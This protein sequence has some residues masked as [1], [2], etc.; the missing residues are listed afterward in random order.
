MIQITIVG[1]GAYGSKIS[2]K[3]KKFDN[4]KVRAVISRSKSKSDAFFGVPF[5]K[6]AIEWKNNF[7]IPNKNDVFDV[8]VHQNILIRVLNDLTRIGVRNFILPKPIALNKKEL[9]HIKK[10]TRKYNL[11]VVIASQWHYSDLIKKVGK[12]LEKNKNKISQVDI[13]FSRPF[14]SYRKSVYNSKT[15]FSSSRLI[16]KSNSMFFNSPILP[17]SSIK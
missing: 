8:C 12:F 16:T 4:V 14:D 9:D 10:L 11:K 3:Y 13:V 6:S 17:S 7:G 1:G 15:S 5:V 2:E